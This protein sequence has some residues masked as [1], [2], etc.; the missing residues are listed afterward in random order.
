MIRAPLLLVAGLLIMTS[1]TGQ[2]PSSQTQSSHPASG[3]SSAAT[4]SVTNSPPGPAASGCLITVSVKATHAQTPTQYA[5][6]GVIDVT[7]GQRLVVAAS[8]H[9][10][11][12]LQVRAQPG[13]VLTPVTGSPGAFLAVST[14]QV[15]L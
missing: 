15:G 12:S 2:A 11:P 6:G 1:C 7:V 5:I 10:A 8:D 14:G 4:T 3:S 13:G 9:C